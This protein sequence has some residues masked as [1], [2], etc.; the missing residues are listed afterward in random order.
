MNY[1]NIFVYISTSLVIFYEILNLYFLNRFINKNMKISVV[2]PQFII[3]WL[4]QLEEAASNDL[5]IKIVKE[6]CYMHISIYSVII[7]LITI[8]YW[9]V[10]SI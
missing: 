4:K 7:I 6:I 3:N 8:L 10:K 9:I 1:L 5:T 2:L